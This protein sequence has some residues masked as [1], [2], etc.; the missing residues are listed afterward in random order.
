MLRCELLVTATGRLHLL[1]RDL[2]QVALR[3]EPGKKLK[4]HKSVTVHCI[5]MIAI[6]VLSHVLVKHA[7][8]QAGSQKLCVHV[9]WMSHAAHADAEAAGHKQPPAAVL[10]KLALLVQ[11]PQHMLPGFTSSR[12]AVDPVDACNMRERE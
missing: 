10:E 8:L 5:A 6:A 3:C 7:A 1:H 12:A 11:Q 9:Q 2:T 4:R